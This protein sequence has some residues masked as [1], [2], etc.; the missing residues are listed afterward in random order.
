MLLIEEVSLMVTTDATATPSPPAAPA[1]STAVMDSSEVQVF[2]NKERAWAVLRRN[3][4]DVD[5]AWYVDTNVSNHM[6]GDEAV[7]AE[8]D[9]GVS[10]TVKFGDGSLVAIQGRGTVLFSIGNDENRAL[11]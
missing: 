8:L 10:G 1:S 11:T 5:A 3:P 9:K 4:E 6:S 2:L 7:F